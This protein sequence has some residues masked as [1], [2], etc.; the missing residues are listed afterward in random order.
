M[1]IKHLAACLPLVSAA[2]LL[3]VA[4]ASWIGNIYGFGVRNLFSADGI[5]WEVTNFIANMQEAPFAVI[6]ISLIALSVVARSGLLQALLQTFRRKAPL[7]QRRALSLVVAVLI[8]IL[9]IIALL[10]IP[11]GAVLRSSFG[12]ITQSPFTRG[13]FGLSALT[14]IICGNVFGVM[15]GHFASLHDTLRAHTHLLF[16]CP[17]SIVSMLVTA[18][19]CAAATYSGIVP[20]SPFACNAIAALLYCLPFVIELAAAIRTKR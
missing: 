4:A 16:Q 11:S 3:V 6:F 1:K 18:Q 9:V 5:R 12:T 15:A 14:C 19:L 8:L 2:L 17:C 10:L 20:D 13:L 7:K